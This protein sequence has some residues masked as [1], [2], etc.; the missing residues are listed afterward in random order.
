M[1]KINLRKINLAENSGP[2]D[3]DKKGYMSMPR[4]ELNRPEQIENWLTTMGSVLMEEGEMILIGSGALLWHAFQLGVNTHLPENSMDADPIT[5]SDCVAEICYDQMIQS[6]FE[7]KEGWHVNL[8]PKTALRE[9]P[10]DWETRASQKRY[11]KLMVTV[12]SIE[13]IMIPKRRR[14]EARDWKHDTY[15]TELTN[16]LQ[17]PHPVEKSPTQSAREHPTNHTNDPADP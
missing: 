11:G 15:A 3:N 14:G 4:R 8:M 13:D 1:R 6:E 2:S 10:N 16:S 9:F 5:E 7:Q 17:K 12:P